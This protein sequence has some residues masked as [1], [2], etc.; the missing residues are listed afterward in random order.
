S[1]SGEITISRPCSFKRRIRGGR[2][3][4]P[5]SSAFP[6]IRRSVRRARLP[7]ALDPGKRRT[8]ALSLEIASSR[9]WPMFVFSSICQPYWYPARQNESRFLAGFQHEHRFHTP[10]TGLAFL[11]RRS[12]IPSSPVPEI[13]MPDLASS[14]QSHV[15]P[16]CLRARK[17]TDGLY[18]CILRD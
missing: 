7:F 2:E 5:H 15:F 10:G 6:S 12:P 3:M 14:I 13:V 8:S 9:I 1:I 16:P 4:N 18:R 11:F 17:E